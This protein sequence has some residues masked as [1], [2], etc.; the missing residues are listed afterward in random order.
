MDSLNQE[1]HNEKLLFRN[2]NASRIEIERKKNLLESQLN[3]HLMKKKADLEK[4]IEEKSFRLNLAESD[5]V[6]SEME[7]LLDTL[8][9][10][11]NTSRDEIATIEKTIS[12]L[13][14]NVGIAEKN[15]EKSK[16]RR[17]AQQE[18]LDNE[19]LN[20]S[21]FPSANSSVQI[22]IL[23]FII[24]GCKVSRVHQTLQRCR[25]DCSGKNRNLRVFL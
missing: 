19:I 8:E 16:N 7:N 25:G 1:I 10:R 15:L 12:E 3:D 5:S 21:F 2:A 4:S 22:V 17:N 23:G 11:L 24:S 14:K 18:M 13:S 6:L 9:T 20:V